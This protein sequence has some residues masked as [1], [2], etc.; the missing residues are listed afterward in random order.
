M[1]IVNRKRFEISK[2]VSELTLYG[3][4]IG[5]ALSGILNELSIEVNSTVLTAGVIAIIAGAAT[6]LWLAK[7]EYE[8]AI[9]I[10]KEIEIK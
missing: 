3:G 8:D 2:K 5:V 7:V 9:G 10:Y 6:R 4:I 1:K